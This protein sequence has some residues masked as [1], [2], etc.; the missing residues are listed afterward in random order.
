MRL[1]VAVDQDAGSDKII[2]YGANLARQ[3]GGTIHLLHVI[4]G[5]EKRGREHIPGEGKYIDVMMEEAARDLVQRGINLGLERSSFSVSARVGDPAPEIEA[6]SKELEHDALV[7]GMRTRSRVGKFLLGSHF[8]E[9]LRMSKVP[10]IAV[11][12][13]GST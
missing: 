4:S 3:T 11:P 7:I 2:E 8:Q 10:V 1:L 6:A 13:D 5:E 12:I 9:L